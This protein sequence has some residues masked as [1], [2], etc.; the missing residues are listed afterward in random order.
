MQRKSNCIWGIL[1]IS[2]FLMTA[3][4]VW[5][6]VTVAILNFENN[7]IMA[8]E[9]WAPLSKGLAQILTS[10]IDAVA[11]MRVVERRRIQ[12]LMD[13]VKLAQSG[14]LDSRQTVSVGKL[15]GARFM[16]FG[17]F[18]VDLKEKIRIDMRLV[19][20]ETGETLKAGQKTG[21]AR[22]F[23]KLMLKLTQSILS[24]IEVPF[25]KAEKRRFKSGKAHPVAALLS[26]AKGV[27]HE[28]NHEL[29]DAV[30]CYRKALEIDPDFEAASVQLDIMR[31]RLQKK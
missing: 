13:E 22:D 10:E 18:I 1:V 6:Q 19:N 15:A 4:T 28:D 5:S 21:K 30:V 12:D 2:G 29:R 3:Q 17:A 16:I 27:Q 20:V 25:T 31:N 8:R 14:L 11:S 26:Y 9:K 24:D 7:S 23:M